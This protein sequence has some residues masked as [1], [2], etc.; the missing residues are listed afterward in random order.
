M[1]VKNNN[2]KWIYLNI[3]L[4]VYTIFHVSNLVTDKWDHSIVYIPNMSFH[5]KIICRIKN[6]IKCSIKVTCYE[7][8]LPFLLHS[9]LSTIKLLFFMHMVFFFL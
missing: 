4:F 7:A 3:F 2:N 8:H 5:I 1:E 6:L 9:L